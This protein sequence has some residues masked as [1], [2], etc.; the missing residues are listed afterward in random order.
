LIMVQVVA[1]L[2]PNA[3]ACWSSDLKPHDLSAWAMPSIMFLRAR[4]V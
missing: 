2:R 3:F 4:T 1:R